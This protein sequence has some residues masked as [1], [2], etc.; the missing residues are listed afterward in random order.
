MTPSSPDDFAEL[1]DRPAVRRRSWRFILPAVVGLLLLVAGVTVK[2]GYFVRRAQ[3]DFYAPTA[4]GVAI[5]TK[6]KL[7]GFP[8]GAVSAVHFIPA[9][10]GQT[11]RV[12]FEARIDAEYLAHIP[13]GSGARLAQE[14]VIGERVIEILPGAD[15]ARPMAAGESIELTKGGGLGDLAA[16]VESRVLPVADEARTLLHALNDEQAGVKPLIADFRAVA[17]DAAASA[18]QAGKMLN[19]MDAKV[20]R[21]LGEGDA[22]MKSVHAVAETAERRSAELLD[23][24][25]ATL[26]DVRALA[27][28]GADIARDIRGATPGLIAEG[29]SV[30]GDVS[31]LARGAKR[32][33]PIRLFVDEPGTGSLGV[34]TGRLPQ[35]AQEPAR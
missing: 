13:A 25:R 5:G 34:D 9:R 15:S 1:L 10:A 16:T 19:H 30:A 2:Q 28:D 27:A 23:D 32:S 14:G 11:R 26:K 12:K 35:H 33:W 31:E 21:I 22:A 29:Q 20:D 3:L 6:I 24:A 17:V 18:Q 8:I 7:M 4:D